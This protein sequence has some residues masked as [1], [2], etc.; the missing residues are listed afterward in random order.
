M[1]AL[2]QTLADLW[3]GGTLPVLGRVSIRLRIAALVGL[4]LGGAAAFGAVYAYAAHRTDAALVAQDGF[5]RLNDLAAEAQARSLAMQVHAEQFLRERDARHA[6][7]F[8]ADIARVATAVSA[9]RAIP[10]SRNEAGRLAELAD[11]FDAL[12]GEFE[13]MAAEAARL[14]LTEQDGLRG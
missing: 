12:A 6:D 13:H 7:S 11:G 2:R 5:R 3:Q 14:G 8:R 10:E 9:M 1:A 4:A